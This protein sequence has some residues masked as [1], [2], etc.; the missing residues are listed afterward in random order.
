M[1]GCSTGNEEEFNK[2]DLAALRRP[3]LHVFY[4]KSA[5]A[6]EQTNDADLIPAQDED[7]DSDRSEFNPGSSMD[8]RESE[9]AVGRKRKRRLEHIAIDGRERNSADIAH[10][11]PYATSCARLYAPLAEA[12]VG[13]DLSQE[14]PVRKKLK[15]QILVQGLYTWNDRTNKYERAR[16][17]G[18][19]HCR[20]NMARVIAQK[21]YLDFNPSLIM[22][23]IM[24]LQQVLEYDGGHG[25]RYSVLVI[26]A[27]PSVY[28]ETV[29]TKQYDLCTND[30]IELA[31]STLAYFVK[32]VAFSLVNETDDADIKKLNVPREKKAIQRTKET[33]AE[34]GKV[35]IPEI[36]GESKKLRVAKLHFDLATEDTHQECDPFLLYV[37]AAVVWSSLQ[38]QKLLP[39]C[40]R[41]HNCE[42]CLEQDLFSCQCDVAFDPGTPEYLVP[43]IVQ[44]IHTSS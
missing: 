17:T 18:V 7:E 42:E 11:L 37:K 10:L 16:A 28:E 15:R 8:S 31:T 32:G 44:I 3:S 30:D 20:T 12:A 14:P 35:R 41:P 22:I 9:S 26:A 33:L 43:V 1:T 25:G 4:H 24:T 5:L 19:K 23:P 29:L 34:V 13:L 21:K 39:G 27:K 6:T 40:P 36:C 2:F 38:G